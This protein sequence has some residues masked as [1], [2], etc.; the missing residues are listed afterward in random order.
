MKSATRWVASILTWRAM[1]FALR[2][3]QLHIDDSQVDVDV[4]PFAQ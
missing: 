2:A 3:A 1:G 4:T